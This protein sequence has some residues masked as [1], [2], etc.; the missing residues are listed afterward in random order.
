MGLM[1]YDTGSFEMT[2]VERSEHPILPSN[3]RHS[4]FV[5]GAVGEETSVAFERLSSDGQ[6]DLSVFWTL[7]THWRFT[8]AV[9]M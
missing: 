4:P 5:L 6:P 8:F 2:L 9:P 1:R 7:R 3:S